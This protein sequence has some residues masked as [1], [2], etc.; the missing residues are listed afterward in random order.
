MNPRIASDTVGPDDAQRGLLYHVEQEKAAE[1]N[2]RLAL[3]SQ[4]G[5]YGARHRRVGYDSG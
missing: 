4:V 1:D 2:A 3:Y 5:V